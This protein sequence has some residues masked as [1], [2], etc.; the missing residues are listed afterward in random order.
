GCVGG[1]GGV[2]AK[3][4]SGDGGP[5]DDANDV[6]WRRGAGGETLLGG[7]DERVHSEEFVESGGVPGFFVDLAKRGVGGVLAGFYSA[8]RKGP[9]LAAA[10]VPVG[11]EHLVAFDDDAVRPDAD[12]HPT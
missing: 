10:F 8:A 1:R 7:D 4:T 2:V 3:H 5:V 12:V 11:E 9:A 6:E